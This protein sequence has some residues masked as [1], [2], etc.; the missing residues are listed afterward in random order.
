V[1][2][3][4]GPGFDGDIRSFPPRID[5]SSRLL[6]LQ[7]YRR[8]H[9]PRPDEQLLKKEFSFATLLQYCSGQSESRSETGDGVCRIPYSCSVHSVYEI[10]RKDGIIVS[11]ELKAVSE[12]IAVLFL[13]LIDWY[14]EM[15]WRIRTPLHRNC[16][17][18]QLQ[19]RPWN[20]MWPQMPKDQSTSRPTHQVL[21][22]LV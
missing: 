10:F 1:H 13:D 7:V 18:T 16:R 6:V 22:F 4:T 3:S 17:I 2:P 9:W 20:Q 15:N 8:H 11:A 12:I 21:R 5:D 19:S 14:S